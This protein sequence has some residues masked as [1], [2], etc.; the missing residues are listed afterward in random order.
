MQI[1]DVSKERLSE[2]PSERILILTKNQNPIPKDLPRGFRARGRVSSLAVHID[3]PVAVAAVPRDTNVMPS[4]VVWEGSFVRKVLPM[5]DER[6]QDSSLDVQLASELELIGENW[7]SVGE[8]GGNLVPL[9]VP[10][11][12]DAHAEERQVRE[13]HI[14]ASK[15]LMRFPWEAQSGKFQIY[16]EGKNTQYTSLI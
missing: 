15:G 12:T 14:D 6:Q 10:L 16:K 2:V 5:D 13:G 3:I 11:D 1:R 9:R 7:C 8:D 4:S